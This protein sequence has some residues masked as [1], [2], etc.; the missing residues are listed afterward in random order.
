MAAAPPPPDRGAASRSDSGHTLVAMDR[1]PEPGDPCP[2]SS[3]S[4]PVLP[5]GISH[6]LQAT[7]RRE[8]VADGRVVLAD[9]ATA[10]WECPDHLDELTG[11]RVSED[12]A[13]CQEPLALGDADGT[14]AVTQPAVRLSASK[15]ST[16]SRCQSPFVEVICLTRLVVI[17]GSKR[18]HEL[19]RRTRHNDDRTRERSLPRH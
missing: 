1:M 17:S 18:S 16:Q 11:Y 19:S 3:P 5:D 8:A 14:G 9:G 7:H 15:G 12:G 10:G 4:R 2:R 6:Q 13:S